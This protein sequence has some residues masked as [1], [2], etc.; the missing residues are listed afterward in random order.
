MQRDLSAILASLR[1]VIGTEEGERSMAD[2]LQSTRDLTANLSGLVSDNREKVDR[3]MNNLDGLTAKLD[4][5][6]GDNREDV[7]Q[8]IANI[9][10]VSETIREDLPRLTGKLEGAADQ[11]TG[12]LSDNR[13][14]VKETIERIRKDAEILEEALESIKVVAKRIEEGEGTVGKLINEDD[15]YVSL[16]ETLSGLNKAMKKGVATT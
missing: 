2:I 13:E 3:I 9:R 7:R 1:K 4:G 12:V 14:S 8:V 15:T 16:N 6:A 5:M 10:E 11:V